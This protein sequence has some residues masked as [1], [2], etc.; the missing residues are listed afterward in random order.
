MTIT[1]LVVI[2]LAPMSLCY[3]NSFIYDLLFIHPEAN[4]AVVE[5]RLFE[6]L[7]HSSISISK[8]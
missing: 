3:N 1:T 2:Y 8:N 6:F 4:M 5:K 7:K